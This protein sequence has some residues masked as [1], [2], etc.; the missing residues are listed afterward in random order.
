[1]ISRK[2]KTV[3]WLIFIITYFNHLF[4]LF[5]KLNLKL[6]PP[7]CFNRWLIIVQESLRTILELS[8][9]LTI[10]SKL[11]VFDPCA[12][13]DQIGAVAGDSCCY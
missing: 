13:A 5:H 3:D 1:M 6:K 8:L 2:L 10:F 12:T 9:P 11:L 7:H 4:A